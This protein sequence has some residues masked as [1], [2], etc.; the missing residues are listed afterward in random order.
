MSINL[1]YVGGNSEK[2]R[3]ILT[4][5]KIGSTLYTE[6]TSHELL[7][8]PKDPVS[9]EDNSNIFDKVDRSNCGE[10]FFGE[11]KWSVKSHPNEP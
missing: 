1:P 3:R 6:N 2:L 4:S 8:K 5:H 7:C 9:A 10:V 11:F